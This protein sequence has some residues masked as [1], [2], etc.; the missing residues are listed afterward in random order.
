MVQPPPRI[1]VTRSANQG[2]VLADALWALGAEPVLIPAIAIAPPSSFC[3][4]DA[5]LASL[6]SFEW[7]IFT[8]ANAVEAFAQRARRLSPHLLPPGNRVAAIGPA[9]AEALRQIGVRDPLI[10]PTAV[11]ESLAQQMLPH[12]RRPDGTPTRML[13][14]RAETA[15]DVLPDALLQAGA[16]LTVAPVYRNIIP[17]ESIPR[18]RELFTAPETWPD[19]ITFTSSSTVTNLLALLEAAGVTL[20][21][22]G[23][24]GR[25]ILRASIGPVT[26]A[27]LREAG[28]PP[29]VEAL[30]ASIPSLVEALAGAFG[31]LAI[32]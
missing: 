1:L 21:P 28:Y 8:S 14:L 15:R 13:L 18:L 16:D 29:H 11:A 30:E 24:H 12:A 27:T 5:A 7:L 17:P 20:P 22:D 6:R 3:P 25:T 32:S 26:S 2:S 10:P 19:A 9:T 4:L 23:S 31:Q